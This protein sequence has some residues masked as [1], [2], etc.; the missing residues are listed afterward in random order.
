M[1]RKRKLQLTVDERA[2]QAL[3]RLAEDSD[4]SSLAEVIRNAISLLDWAKIQTEEGLTV[5]AFKEGLPAKEVVLPF[6]KK[7]TTAS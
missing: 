1:S 3:V 2:Y 5:G 4:A 7:R 6:L